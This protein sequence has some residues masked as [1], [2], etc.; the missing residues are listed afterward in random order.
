MSA[1]RGMLHHASRMAAVTVVSRITGYLRDKAL[2]QVFGAGVFYDAF[3]AAFRIP[4]TFRALL[5]EGALH[6]AFIPSLSR[7]V[8]A[9]ERSSEQARDLV[10]AMLATLILLVSAVVCVGI[11]ASPWLIRAFAP[12]FEQTPG[13]ITL[14]VSLNRLM[15][16]YLLFVSLAALCQGVLNTHDRFVLP[17]VTPIFL[18]LSLV[19]AAWLAASHTDR[20]APVLAGGVL[21][22]GFLQFAVQ[23]VAV[24]RLGYSLRPAWRHAL[25]PEVRTVLL[26]ML[27]GIGV[28]GVNQVN[29]FV[30]TLFASFTGNGG[31]T[32]TYNAYRI[33]E[34]VFGVVVVQLT[35]VLLP[36]LSRDLISDREGARQTLRRTL[37]LVS[38]VTL[39]SAVVL[40]LLAHPIV[41][42]LFGGGRY[43]AEDV[44]VTAA[45]LNAYAFGLVG[46]AVAKVM[47]NAFFAHRDTRTPMIGSLVSMAF[48]VTGCS[49]LALRFGTPGIGWANTLSTTAF[50]IFL[51]TLY[52]RRHGF[53]V[54]GPL[55]GRSA[56][57]VVA[58]GATAGLLLA[59]RPHLAWVSHTELRAAGAVAATLAAAAVIYLGVLRVLG[60][61]EPRMMLDLLRR[62][63]VREDGSE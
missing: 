1:G 38:F 60:G 53:G 4:N 20:P 57:Q 13:K 39:P 54:V 45:T 18:N 62:R 6:A 55:L 33:T 51:V 19:G 34:L 5:A 42:L 28:L 17:A 50:A 10:R 48:F 37:A 24:R 14:A 7:A 26:L 52:A 58:A 44:G 29:Q 31:V 35:T 2:A 46:L 56:R 23:A 9:D 32:Y 47:A 61:D 16:P 40:A 59:A 11:L 43:G 49:L 27:P 30:S 21:V 63:T 22:G 3:L 8:G 41:A 15:F 36:T 12:G 25:D